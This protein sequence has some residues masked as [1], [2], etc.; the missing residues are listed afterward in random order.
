MAC[1]GCS[2]YISKLVVQQST[3]ISWIHVK[4]NEVSY[5]QEHLNQAFYYLNLEL[6]MPININLINV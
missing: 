3:I 2:V 4:I 6:D 5:S 1:N